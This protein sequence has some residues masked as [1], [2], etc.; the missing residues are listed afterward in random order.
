MSVSPDIERTIRTFS[1]VE[2]IVNAMK[3][4]AGVTIKRTEEMVRAVRAYEEQVVRALAAVAGDDP[5][6]LAPE[7]RGGGRILVVFGSSQG[8]CGPLNERV[9]DALRSGLSAGDTL[10]VVGRRL[11][12][13]AEARGLAVTDFRES[14]VSV[15]GIRPVLEET[16]AW[17]LGRYRRGGAYTLTFLFTS[18]SGQRAELVQERILPPN[19]E[20]FAGRG[21]A[22]TPPLRYLGGRSSRGRSGS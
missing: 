20:Q 4:Y 9:A 16:I 2:D 22:G 17:I 5:G 13:A 18:V 15:S 1:S 21:A 10:L 19:L 7:R 8:L 14:V 11:K 3:A 6:L 12:A